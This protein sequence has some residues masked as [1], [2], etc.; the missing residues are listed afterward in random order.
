M[1]TVR[2]SQFNEFSDL[3]SH[4][5][6][7]HKN[8]FNHSHYR[9]SGPTFKCIR[10]ASN[11][12][13]K[14]ELTTHIKEKHISYKPFDYFMESRCDLDDYCNFHHVKLAQG[15]Q[16]CYTCGDCFK[17]KRDLINHIKEKH[18]NIVCYK[19]LQ[20][21]C[22]VRRCFFEHIIQ[23]APNVAK[24]PESPPAPT[25]QDFPCLPTIRPVV[26]SQVAAEDT[27][28]QDLPNLLKGTQN[29]NKTLEAQVFQTLTQMVPQITQQFA[30]ALRTGM[31]T[32]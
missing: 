12:T 10:Y 7:V 1:C 8:E 26:W 21:K 3:A 16:I 2:P 4:M 5:E 9:N 11:F 29:K 32:N 13:T 19:F 25:D 22:T 15:E 31:T 27:Q 6:K 18:G 14:K 28:A 24:T 20:N 30:A 23:S 17:S